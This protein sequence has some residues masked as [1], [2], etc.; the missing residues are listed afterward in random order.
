MSSR[1]YAGP[2][3]LSSSSSLHQMPRL[4]VL[5]GPSPSILSP[6]SVNTS[7]AHDISS[8]LFQGRVVVHIKGFNDDRQE[9]DDI[10]RD[11]YFEREDRQYITWSIQVQ[12]RFLREYD[13]NDILFGNTFDRPLKLPYGSSFILTPV[14]KFMSYIDPT[15]QHDLLSASKPWALSPLISTMPY[16]EHR[17]LEEGKED[18][19][20]WPEFPRKKS[21]H[22]DVSQLHLAAQKLADGSTASESSSGELEEDLKS[23]HL[24]SER[25][26]FFRSTE[27]RKQVVFG[28]SD[29][30]TM[31]FCYG[32][33][34]FSGQTGGPRLAIPG[35]LSFDLGRY[36]DGQP[37]R[38][39][40]CERKPEG[41][42]GASGDEP[43]GRTFWSVAIELAENGKEENA[44]AEDS[45]G[46]GEGDGVEGGSASKESEDID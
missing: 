3:S 23:V 19:G 21:V 34:S 25:Q 16:F 11:D 44:E 30:I 13:A 35:G 43:W 32:F 28:P 31:D 2:R 38:F 6:I 15:L 42:E 8:D 40:C 5:A 4:R 37:V 18:M 14:L 33:L 46:E 17:K 26:A 1:P 45:G 36:W 41:Q 24:P 7:Q 27:K 22:D 10:K 39:V 29:L 12:G 20:Q 9:N